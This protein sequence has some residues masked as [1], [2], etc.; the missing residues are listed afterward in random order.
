VPQ[1]TLKLCNSK[2]ATV[3]LKLC[4]SKR[5]AVTLKKQGVT[6]II[7]PEDYKLYRSKLYRSKRTTSF[8]EA[9]TTSFIEASFIEARG[10]QASLKQGL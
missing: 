6:G 5:A 10:L 2:R 3:T 4:N 8:I 1:L 7:H 9:R